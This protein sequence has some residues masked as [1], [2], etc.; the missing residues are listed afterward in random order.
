MR[1]AIAIVVALAFSSIGL[2]M[3]RSLAQ[4]KPRAGDAPAVAPPPDVRISFWCE[5]CGTELLM[6]RKGSETP[7]RHCG[8]PMIRR[9]EVA[10]GEG[11]A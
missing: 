3:L 6:L 1:I 9:E 4:R 8:E 7:P 5:N 11:R 2:G 10:R